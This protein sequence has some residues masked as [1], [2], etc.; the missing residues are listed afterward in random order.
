MQADPLCCP[1]VRGNVGSL[2]C[3]FVI[4][5][6]IHGTG[7]F[8]YI[9][10][11]CIINVGK[12]TIHGWD[13][14]WLIDFVSFFLYLLM[15]CSFY[16]WSPP[17]DIWLK[18]PKDGQIPFLK[19][20]ARTWKWM[21]R[22][23]V[24]FLGWPIFR[25]ELL[26]SGSVAWSYDMSMKISFAST[27]RKVDEEPTHGPWLDSIHISNIYCQYSMIDDIRLFLHASC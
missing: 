8:T 19:L 20:T 12:Y 22:L 25:C 26:V 14:L 21:V 3:C 9:W 5:H 23:L 13:G 1:P 4:P 17:S 7:I 2:R 18:Q 24:S 15:C 16:E 6:R 10:L 27:P 11:V